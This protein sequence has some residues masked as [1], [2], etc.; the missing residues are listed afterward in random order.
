MI[1]VCPHS[2]AKCVHGMNCAYTCATDAYDGN[3]NL[4]AEQNASRTPAPE[5]EVSLWGCADGNG[6]DPRYVFR[7]RPTAEQVA[8]DMNMVVRPLYA[9]PVVPVG[10]SREEIA[11]IIDPAAFL[12]G[13][14]ELEDK[15]YSSS[16]AHAFDRADAILAALRP[17]DT[18]RRD[19]ATEHMVQRFLRWRLPENFSPDNGIS[20]K[21]TFND[22]MEGGPM[23]HNPVGTNLF[24]YEQAKA[25][26]LH[27]LEGLPK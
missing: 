16:R 26:V 11:R 19:I 25:M 23:Q 17:T 3:K 27:M 4:M 15:V 1:R 12:F 14:G 6:I 7:D 21:P 9:S 22:H 5:G 2:D 8:A 10:V 13:P 20:F 18:G 24:D